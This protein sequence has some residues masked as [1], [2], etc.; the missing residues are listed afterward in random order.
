M[1]YVLLNPFTFYLNNGWMQMVSDY[2][3]EDL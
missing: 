3:T 1:P 2:T